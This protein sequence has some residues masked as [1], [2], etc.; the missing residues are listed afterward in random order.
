MVGKG[1]SPRKGAKCT[2]KY[3]GT[4]PNKQVF[5]KT[6]KKPF[7]FTIGVGE[8]IKGWDQGIMSKF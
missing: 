6:G 4:L 8:V 5:D 2:V 7:V 3:V 1:R